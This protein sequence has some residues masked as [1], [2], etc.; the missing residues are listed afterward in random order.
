MKKATG[1]KKI[2]LAKLKKEVWQLVSI[3]I[4]LRDA[5]CHGQVECIS[6]NYKGYYIRDKIQAG[7]FFQ[8]RNFGGVR[9]N[10]DNIHGQCQF[11]NG[12]RQGNVYRYYKKLV[13]KIGQSRIDKIDNTA[14]DRL[15][16]NI[17]FIQEVKKNA[18]SLI[19]KEAKKKNLYDW[20]QL[21][22]KKEVNS[23]PVD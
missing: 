5:D 19:R 13:S 12:G 21:L 14:D 3:A 11:C 16:E 18:I 20:K 6:C 23:W 17:E 7:H 15:K 1:V 9:W 2:N 10:F 22:T 4:R 8:S